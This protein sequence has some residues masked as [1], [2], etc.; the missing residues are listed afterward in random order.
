MNSQIHR[1]AITGCLLVTRDTVGDGGGAGAVQMLIGYL[2]AVRNKPRGRDEEVGKTRILIMVACALLK[3]ITRMR[4][5][6]Q[7][8]E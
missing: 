1:G 4:V 7:T 8:P 5:S 6:Y 3:G 2:Q